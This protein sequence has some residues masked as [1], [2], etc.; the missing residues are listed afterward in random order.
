MSTVGSERAVLRHPR[1][2]SLATAEWPAW[3]WSADGSRILW[4]NAVGA[5][6]FGA[7]TS[8]AC[9]DRRFS[10]TDPPAA[11]VLHL[12]A[13]LPSGGQE[14]L[15]R[16]RGFGGSLGRAL[17]CTCSRIVVDGGAGA[18][19][20]VAAEPAGP[21]LPLAERVQ[22]LLDDDADPVAA[23][24]PDGRL[25]YAN[26]KAQLWLD[27]TSTLSALGL[28]KLAAA[29]LQAGTT[30][31]GARLN[32][33]AC[34]ILLAC[35]GQGASSVVLVAVQQPA[36]RANQARASKIELETAPETQNGSAQPVSP[37]A[38]SAGLDTPTAPS[39]RATAEIGVATPERRH[40]LRF[41]WDMDADGHFTIASE[42]F[43]QL[44]G[45]RSALLGRRWRDIAAEL[46]LDPA[47]QVA[48]AVASRETWSG[49]T[50]S[51]PISA[52]PGSDRHSELQ[53]PIELSG[54][55]VFDRDRNF[56]G[57][58]GF[59]V[60]RDLAQIDGLAR[61]P[62]GENASAAA[63]PAPH[64]RTTVTAP[65]QAPGGGPI[66][67]NVVQFRPAA[68]VESKPAPSLT[69]IERRA[70]RE[71]AQELTS[72]L[73][74][75][76]AAATAE[77]VAQEL[78]AAGQAQAL[79]Q[80]EL[81]QVLSHALNKDSDEEFGEEPN[82]DAR[83][84][85]NQE[86]EQNADEHP[87][88][89]PGAEAKDEGRT[90][91]EDQ[92]QS[93]NQR[94]NQRQDR[95]QD[96]SEVSSETANEAISEQ[97]PDA[98]KSIVEQS[99]APAFLDRIPLG[100]LVYRHDGLLYANRQF[101]D[102]SGYSDMA[103]I[104]AAG[105]LNKLFAEPGANAAFADS[106]GAA[107]A[108]VT[109]SGERLPV[110]GRMVTVPWNATPAIALILNMNQSEAA[111]S[112]PAANANNEPPAD[113]EREARRNAAAKAEFVAKI[114]HDIRNPL[115]AI[116][117]F[118]EAIMS[119]RFGPIGN[120]RYREYIKD[121][122]AA[123]AHLSSMVNDMFDLSKLES[124]R[125]DLTF[126]TV[127]LNEL[128]QQCV[129]IMQPQANRARIIIRSALT[130]ALPP[131]KADER[132]LRQIVLNLLSNSI[133]FT[134]PGGQIIVSTVFSDTREAILRVRDTGAGMSEKQIV[135]ALE[136]LADID[137][138]ASSG[139]S[140]TEF[141]LPLTKALAEANHAQFRIK[142]APEAGTL[143]EIA[144]P[145]NRTAAE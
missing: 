39:A 132:S 60:C 76:H 82:K 143:V 115:N 16:L 121:L 142:S 57:Y 104:E 86:P 55:P 34:D 20:I 141:G 47:D 117:G 27:G 17:T 103:A 8:S 19:L 107:A 70:F 110:Q 12:A 41:V 139:A 131:V 2:A 123:A 105:G 135:A 24:M 79:S 42:E 126:A 145:Q 10:V 49:I 18:V 106:A 94:Q 136:P 92:G 93:Q 26:A 38:T 84:K 22:R 32:D 111:A 64:G 31:A 80:D 46:K 14:R 99:L 83:Q 102:L 122:H 63:A 29:A 74:G 124:G 96:Q 51:W 81:R 45:A 35:L 134:G 98:A 40:P 13:T 78:S 127:N 75:A 68:A 125:I 36:Q 15:E 90:E 25:V 52:P 129:G 66:S 11:Q 61:P 140:G 44:I 97:P 30:N 133:K 137:A 69:P 91:S 28:E 87:A 113:A 9:T 73:R 72:R 77:A 67:A 53:L 144:F 56:R 85:A 95:H 112:E 108:I 88:E 59:G 138:W 48:A 65:D 116:A 130:S 23:F 3:L 21:A 71:L 7:K 118:A 100:I 4:A 5:A 1:L 43:L 58:R 50:V 54:L 89:R 101:L 120:E 62:R 119:E 37:A 33:D 109:Q 6:I 128:V 114:S